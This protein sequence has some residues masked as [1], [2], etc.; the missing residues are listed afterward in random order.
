MKPPPRPALGVCAAGNRDATN[1]RRS[2]GDEGNLMFAS[3]NVSAPS[4]RRPP[5]GAGGRPGRRR[6]RRRPGRPGPRGPGRGLAAERRRGP[7][8]EIMGPST[9]SAARPTN[10]RTRGEDP[11]RA[12]RGPSPRSE[13]SPPPSPPRPPM[14]AALC[15]ATAQ[16]A[17][18]HAQ[19]APFR[20]ARGSP[21]RSIPPR[22]RS[23]RCANHRSLIPA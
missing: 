20:P 5:R 17:P 13:P 6:G 19:A 16:A 15:A 14:V 10:R 4:R 3:G 12:V 21:Q 11:A 22:P 18:R 8:T 23:T 7:I 2:L 1:C 9:R